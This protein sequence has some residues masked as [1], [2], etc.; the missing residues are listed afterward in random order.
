MYRPAPSTRAA[1]P[2]R[3]KLAEFLSFVR[4][5]FKFDGCAID[6]HVGAD[7][8]EKF[9]RRSRCPV[10]SVGEVLGAG[11]YDLCFEQA[12]RRE[13]PFRHHLRSVPK[14]TRL[15]D[16]DIPAGAMVL[17]LW[18]AA[19]RDPAVFERPDEVVLG[20]HRRHVAFGRDIH[21][22]V[23]AALASL[24]ARVVLTVLLEGT[25]SITLDP[26]RTPRWVNSLMVRRHEPLPV[27]LIPQ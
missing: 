4:K 10:V 8:A 7:S 11:Q 6:L 21:Y 15:G 13:S 14:D 22:C 27:Q 9:F 16:V 3:E 5:D 20:R 26:D 12:L 1:A 25:S 24:E 23:G 19:N 2:V 18:G 17:L